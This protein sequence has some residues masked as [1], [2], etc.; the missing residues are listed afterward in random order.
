MESGNV[1]FISVWIWKCFSQKSI[2][3]VHSGHS[4]LI[5]WFYPWDFPFSYYLGK[6][7]ITFLAGLFNSDIIPFFASCLVFIRSHP[8]V[9]S[10]NDQGRIL[11]LACLRKGKTACSWPQTLLQSY[12]NQRSTVL[13]QIWYIDK[14]NRIDRGRNKLIPI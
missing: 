9:V 14:W 2:L 8:W 6:Y 1:S 12:N 3:L 7:S 5:T 10:G 11:K 13:E 4:P